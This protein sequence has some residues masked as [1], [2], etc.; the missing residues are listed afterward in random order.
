MYPLFAA[1]LRVGALHHRSL[2]TV[3]RQVIVKLAVLFDESTSYAV[4][5]LVVPFV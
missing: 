3:V 2:R 5:Q 1:E 4:M